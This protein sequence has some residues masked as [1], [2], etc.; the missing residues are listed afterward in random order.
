[1]VVGGEGEIRGPGRG[2]HPACLV[3]RHSKRLLAKHMLARRNGRHGLGEV[4]FIGRRD[5][6]RLHIGVGERLRQIRGRTGNSVLC[7][8]VR[9]APGGAGNYQDDLLPTGP[10]GADHVLGGNRARTDQNPTHPAPP[11]W[12]LPIQYWI[13]PFHAMRFFC[14]GRGHEGSRREFPA[15]G[16]RPETDFMSSSERT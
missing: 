12:N 1:M 14:A 16:C 6:D 11:I 10:E 2:N 4:L 5:V 13:V 7:R 15:D 8:I 3:D 9:R